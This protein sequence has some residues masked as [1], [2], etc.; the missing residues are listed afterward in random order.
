MSTTTF[1]RILCVGISLAWGWSLA[2]EPPASVV[3]VVEPAFFKDAKP[4]PGIQ[5]AKDVFGPG[6]DGYGL[7]YP[8]PPAIRDE[9]RYVCKDVPEGDYAV[10]VPTTVGGYGHF[11]EILPARTLFYQNDQRLPWTAHTEP[12]RR[13]NAAENAPYQAEMIVERVHVKPGDVFRVMISGGCYF[14]VGPLRL[15]REAPTPLVRLAVPKYIDEYF[16]PWLYAD[17]STTKRD[18]DT[19]TQ[20]YWLLNP[21]VTPV[22]FSV[23]VEARDYLQSNLLSQVQSVTLGAGEAVTNTVVFNAGA[24]KRV[25]LTVDVLGVAASPGVRLSRFWVA[26]TRTGPRPTLDLG[27]E[28]EMC[29]VKGAE[30]GSAPPA[31][32]KWVKFNAPQHVNATNEHCAWFRRSFDAPAYLQGERIAF[33]SDALPTESWFYLN[34]QAAGHELHGSLP[35]SVDFTPA[36][37]PGQKNELLIAVRDWLAYSPVNQERVKNGEEAIFKDSMID[38]ADYTEFTGF[39]LKGPLRIEAHPAVYVDDVFVVTDVRAKKLTLRYRLTNTGGADQSVTLAPRIL[40]AGAP[41]L[42]LPAQKAVVPAGSNATITIE[43]PW[44][45]ARLWWPDDPHLYVLDTALTPASGAPDRHLERFGFRDMHIEGINFVLNGVPVKRRGSC[46]GDTG[47]AQARPLSDP[48]RRWQAIWDWQTYMMRD[49]SVELART[50][51]GSRMPEASE[52]ADETG[53]MLQVEGD[54]HQVFFTLDPTFWQAVL[55]HEQRLVAAF[56]NHASTV[57]WSAGNENMWGGAYQ[58]EAVRTVGNKW[59][60]KIAQAMVDADLMRRPVNWEADNDLFGKWDNYSTHYPRE[61]SEHPDLPNG[62]WWGPLDGKTVIPSAMGAIT[63]GIKPVTVGEAYWAANLNRPLG[64]SIIEGDDVYLD[65]IY[66]YASW[67]DSSWYLVHGLRDVEAAFILPFLP[68]AMLP[69]QQVVLKEETASFYGGHRLARQVNVHSDIAKSATLTLRWSLTAADGKIL[70]RGRRRLAMHP[71]ELNRLTLNVALPKVTQRVDATWRVE[72]LDGDKVVSAEQRAWQIHPL[73]SLKAPPS[74]KLAVY[75]PQG[76]AATLLKSMHMPFT[77]LPQLQ[78]PTARVDAL[79]IGEEALKQA[80]PGG[81]REALAAFVRDG[82]KVV[83]LAQSDAPDFLPVPLTQAKDKRITMA[84]LRAA[85]HPVMK[86]LA[87]ADLRWWADDH[88][89]STNNYRKPTQGNWLPLV[90]VGTME[91]MLETPLLE[92]FDGKGSY[93]LCQML[94]TEKAD[95]APQATVLWQNLLDYLAMPAPVRIGG[96]TA[97]LAGTNAS[98]RVALDASQLV[99]EDL[100]GRTGDLKPGQFRVAIVDAA[101]ALDAALVE[102]LK[103]FAQSGGKVMICG[104]APDKQA[105][106]ESLLGI[107]LQFFPVAKEPGDTQSRVLRT[108]G[109]GLLA[110]ISNH[111]FLWATK[112]YLNQ[113]RR[114][115]WWWYDCGPRPADEWIAAYFCLPVAADAA[116]AVALTRPCALLQ[117]PADKGVFLLNQLRLD[118]P[119]A[120]VEP[121][122]ARLRSLLL[123]NLGCTLRSPG[124]GANA[125][126]QRLANY[127]FMPIDLTPYANRGLKDDKAAGIIGWSNQGENDMRSLPTGRQSFA[128]VPFAIAAPKS[129]VVLYSISATGNKELPKEVKGIKVNARAD[130]LFFLHGSAYFTGTGTCFVYRVHYSD[131][132]SLDVPMIYGRQVYDWWDDPAKHADMIARHNTVV[133]WRGDNPMRKGVCLL[134]YEWVNPHPDKTITDIDF[135]AAQESR[136]EPIPSLVG[137]TAA[138]LQPSEGVIEDVIDTRGVKVRLGTQLKD[139][140]YIGTT[141]IEKSNPFYDQAVAAHR[142]M[143]VGQKVTIVPDVVTQNAAGQALA[144][145]YLGTATY[146]VRNMLN[147]RVVGDGLGKLGN[148]EGNNQHR[149]YLENLGFITQQGKKGMWGAGK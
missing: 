143:A 144:Y 145:V 12:V 2:A 147:A 103:A 47:Y 96:Q 11:G 9:V 80:P 77:P 45:G 20:G 114:E 14:I 74:L 44:K 28:W 136:F 90:D 56:K 76:A 49:R 34:G 113:M 33:K 124:G 32:A 112:D 86:G 135:A 87:S 122:V 94:L 120:D 16:N 64:G 104:A 68:L 137:L 30:P 123:N 6:Q 8:G 128:G 57:Q 65:G 60:V 81:W 82:G 71:A 39:G 25:R 117:V 141:G 88:Y 53:L 110:G 133:G 19:I 132:S 10:G 139:V 101:S 58:G 27:G 69:H 108:A 17:W 48:A 97:L 43:Q 29:W 22:T 78:M 72:L 98:L 89:V 4:A 84:Y 75:D 142:A 73:P 100:T 95:V 24:T 13:V 61:M 127:Q 7:W 149:M 148:F 52:I 126:A 3:R 62:A 146:E 91:G 66:V 26:D 18:G 54:T 107:K 102:P 109:G 118:Q 31:D 99:Y 5:P 46:I 138:S 92:E 93:L 111:E 59:Q 116:K 70:D 63:L 37:K 121:T 40:D 35:F 50:H 119:A 105:L 15:Y 42:S 83:I 106:L 79:L 140:Y 131:G 125:R 115:G 134:C 1:W 130:S 21:G 38:D 41:A 23:R 51:L 67:I 36:F 55:A 85:E 129:A